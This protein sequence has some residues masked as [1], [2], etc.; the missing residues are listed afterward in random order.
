MVK[1]QMV[2]IYDEW[3]HLVRGVVI[4]QCD[5]LLCIEVDGEIFFRTDDE[6]VSIIDE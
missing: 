1:G 5:D 4:S 3:S 2:S 6:I